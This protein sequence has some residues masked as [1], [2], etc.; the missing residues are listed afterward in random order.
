MFVLIAGFQQLLKHRKSYQYRAL[1]RKQCSLQW[2]Q[3][4]TNCCQIVIP[5]I[6]VSLVGLTQVLIQEFLVSKIQTGNKVI[7]DPSQV[8]PQLISALHMLSWSVPLFLYFTLIPV[9]TTYHMFHY[10]RLSVGLCTDPIHLSSVYCSISSNPLSICH[11]LHVVHPQTCNEQVTLQPENPQVTDWQSL[12]SDIDWQ[13]YGLWNGGYWG[14]TDQIGNLTEDGEVRRTEWCV[15][16][17][18]SQNIVP[19]RA[20]LIQPLVL[21][22]TMQ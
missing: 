19:L 4:W 22:Q 20:S 9:F 5:L 7:P 21:G 12:P 6:L 3:K 10:Y 13:Y 15:G 11:A 16:R 18:E 1:L 2:R 8:C 14:G 17:L